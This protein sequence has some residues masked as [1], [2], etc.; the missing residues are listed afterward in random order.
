MPVLPGTA[1]FTDLLEKLQGDETD[2][3]FAVSI[4]VPRSTYTMVRLGHRYPNERLVNGLLARFQD[5]S[6]EI[7]AEYGRIPPVEDRRQRKRRTAVS[8]RRSG[9]QQSLL[10]MIKAGRG[11]EARA[12][13]HRA[14]RSSETPENRLWLLDQLADLE[15]ASGNFEA[16]IAAW[17][18]AL[19]VAIE[20][21]FSA[22][23]IELRLRLASR[24]MNRELYS[25][26]RSVLDEGLMRVPSAGRLWRRK[27]IV[28]WHEHDYSNAY[29]SLIAARANGVSADSVLYARGQV[30]AEWGSFDAAVRDLT[31]ALRQGLTPERAAYVR[32]TRAYAY[33]NLGKTKLALREFAVAERV[34][35]DN[36]WLH[37]FRALCHHLMGNTADSVEGLRRALK[38]DVP[39]LNVK[40]REHALALLSEVGVRVEP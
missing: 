18:Q 4:G 37:Y 21:E 30:L 19:T 32:T 33:A 31:Q 39:P 2:V 20:T 14:L 29:S 36:A 40:K 1:D 23:E 16:G 12:G 13:I 35:P 17:E 22:D 15:F 34:T 38:S 5:H 6:E 25:R 3:E 24:L 11:P 10:E 27:G 26:A 9:F 8:P 7:V 28:H